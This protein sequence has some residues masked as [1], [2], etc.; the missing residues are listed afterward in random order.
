MMICPLPGVTETKPGSAQRAAA[1]HLRHRRRRR[2]Q[3]GARTAAAATSCSP[4][5]GR[6]CSAPSGA[7]TSASS[8]PTGP[9]SRASTSPA[10]APRRTTTA[11]SGCSAGSTTSCSSPGTTSPPPRSSRRS[12]PTRRSPRRPSSAP[13]DRDHRSGHRRL[14]DPARHAPPRTTDLVAELRNHVGATLG[15][16]AKPKRILPVAELPKTRSGKIMRRLLRDVAEN[17]AARRRH[18][19]DRLLRHGP[20][21][22]QA[23]ERGQRGL[24][25]RPIRAGGASGTAGCP[26]P[27]SGCGAPVAVRFVNTAE[28]GRPCRCAPPGHTCRTMVRHDLT[29]G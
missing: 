6:R 15:P 2:G 3:R 1:R 22:G 4:S 19:A 18:H 12:S 9:A 8:T 13:T 25:A 5:R 14:R 29:H 21:P 27:R 7:T 26:S 28:T 10:T 20:D 16:I 24:I 11:T 17:R 23:A